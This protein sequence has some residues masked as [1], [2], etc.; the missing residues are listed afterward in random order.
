MLISQSIKTKPIV[1][2]YYIL[3]KPNID[4]KLHETSCMLTMLTE[5]PKY[6]A[7]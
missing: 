7:Q 1:L 2:L 6:I 3:F 4:G 5:D